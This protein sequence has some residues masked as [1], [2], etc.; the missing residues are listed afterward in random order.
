VNPP[1]SPPHY[2]FLD[3]LR[4][5]AALTVALGHGIIPLPHMLESRGEILV[6]NALRLAT[7]GSAAVLL[8]FVISGF[9]IHLPQTRK[10]IEIP[11]FLVRRL[12]RLLLPLAAA[13]VLAYALGFR[14]FHFDDPRFGFGAT[15]V[16]SLFCEVTYY[17]VYALTQA[18]GLRHHWRWVFLASIPVAVAAGFLTRGDLEFATA[19]YLP[20]TIIGWPVWLAGV[21]I[22]ERLPRDRPH[23]LPSC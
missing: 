4:G 17:I 18:T 8:F 3:T 23:K 7:N 11:A 10:A 14:W 22:A 15:I 21:L 6:S 1:D 20:A 12:A 19:G 13:T 16:W 5:G 9:C 2:A